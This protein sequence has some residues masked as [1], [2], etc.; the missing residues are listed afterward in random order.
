MMQFQVE[1][2]S[3]SHCVKAVT[4]AV[5]ALDANAKVD[6]DLAAGSVRVESQRAAG[7]IA[8]AITEAGYPARS[9]NPA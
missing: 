2:M 1:G 9:G 4:Q 5:Q 8:A 6:V 7:D 3:C